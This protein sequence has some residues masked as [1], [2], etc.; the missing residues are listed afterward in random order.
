MLTVTIRDGEIVVSDDGWELLRDAARRRDDCMSCVC[1]RTVARIGEH[2]C[3]VNSVTRDVYDMVGHDL[4]YV[5]MSTG[6]VVR[7]VVSWTRWLAGMR[8]LRSDDAQELASDAQPERGRE[9]EVQEHVEE[10]AGEGEED[11]PPGEGGQA[12]EARA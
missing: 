5:G 6:D 2:E 8:M 9:V 10:A 4:R 1:T 3:R 11:K 12:G 7:D